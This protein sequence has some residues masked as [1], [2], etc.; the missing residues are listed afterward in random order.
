M[1]KSASAQKE[2]R[3]TTLNNRS[4]YFRVG[5]YADFF[6]GFFASSDA[7]GTTSPAFAVCSSA[8]TV[9]SSALATA[10]DANTVRII[11]KPLNINYT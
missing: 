2:F 11:L 3:M 6:A 5:P 9:V 4:L 8:T 7:A 1:K 10:R